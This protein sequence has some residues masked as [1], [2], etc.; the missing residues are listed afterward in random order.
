VLSAFGV[1]T[2]P[3]EILPY[4]LDEGDRRVLEEVRP[5]LPAELAQALGRDLCR[6]P[7]QLAQARFAKRLFDR[8]R[9]E[10]VV[11]HLERAFGQEE[12]QDDGRTQGQRAL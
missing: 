9:A 3:V 8:P 12:L 6:V 7:T 5:V 10:V 1:S 11:R 4:A 2:L